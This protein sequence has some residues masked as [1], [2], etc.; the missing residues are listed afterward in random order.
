MRWAVLW[1]STTYCSVQRF[2]LLL[3]SLS[4]WYAAICLYSQCYSFYRKWKKVIRIR[5]GCV[6]FAISTWKHVRCRI[7][8]WLKRRK[9]VDDCRDW[10]KLWRVKLAIIHVEKSMEN[11]V[12]IETATEIQYILLL[13]FS[14]H[15]DESLLSDWYNHPL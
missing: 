7:V 12:S 10:L 2:L 5:I 1:S 8:S 6:A 15:I 9:L 14:F 4:T 11:H 13:I 3:V